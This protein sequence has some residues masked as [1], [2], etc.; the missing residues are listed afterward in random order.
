MTPRLGTPSHG[1][2]CE[3]IPYGS[4]TVRNTNIQQMFWIHQLSKHFAYDVG[5]NHVVC[6]TVIYRRHYV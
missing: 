6:E 5:S 2:H 4:I 1:Q 3:I